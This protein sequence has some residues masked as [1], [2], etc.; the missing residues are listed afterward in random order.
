MFPTTDSL[1]VLLRS[2]VSLTIVWLASN[3]FLDQPIACGQEATDTAEVTEPTKDTQSPAVE[4]KADADNT[5][6]DSEKT[7]GGQA[8]LDAAIDAKFEAEDLES[9]Q[10]VIDLAQKAVRK[11]LDDGNLAFAKQL[12]AASAFA[13]AQSL[14]AQ[15]SQTRVGA[16]GLS[17]LQSEIM[18]SL[19]LTI[20]NDP[21]LAEAYVMMAKLFAINKNRDEAEKALNSAIEL[22]ADEP[23]QQAEVYVMRA[24]LQQDEQKQIDDLTKAAE[25][26]PNNQAALQALLQVYIAKGENEKAFEIVERLIESGAEDANTFE[27]AVEALMRIEKMDAAM[28]LLDKKVSENPDSFELRRLRGQ[29]N[30]F[31]KK[32]DAAVADL[33]AAIEIAPEDVTSYIL[34]AEA[35]LQSD[36]A[37]LD[38]AT[39]DV[40][41]V[42]ALRPGNIVALQM[43]ASIAAQ[44]EKYDEAIADLQLLVRDDPSN[45]NLLLQLAQLYQADNRPSQSV[46]VLEQVLKQSPNTWQALRSR[47]DSYLSLGQQA[48]AIQDYEDALELIKD[49]PAASSGVMNN[50]SWVLATS[51]KDEIRNGDRALELALEACKL[52]EYKE[53]HILS[54]LGAAYAETGNFEKAREWSAKAVELGKSEESK[55]DQLEQL[56]KEL[57]SYK[58][59]KPWREM[60]ETEETDKPVVQIEEGI[61][62]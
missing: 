23:V 18:E 60:Q 42:L 22:L 33:T 20:E 2:I 9:L 37:N 55:S 1:N 36:P 14:A 7:Y 32:P 15:M 26:N 11:G 8:D 61:E 62:T 34:R 21:K 40:D 12:I 29:A 49:N 45:L 38:E 30:L 3:V 27:I 16:R 39:K 28:E 10:K 43:R 57:E 41:E 48:E 46:K 58:A 24:L 56:E 51:P 53:A 31:S 25:L 17:R 54:T 35:Y 44:L 19:Q 5:K 50:L 47:G 13:R 52:T 6:P 4:E 59:E